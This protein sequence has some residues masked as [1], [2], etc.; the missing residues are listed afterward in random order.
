[1]SPNQQVHLSVKND[2][3]KRTTR[4]IKRINGLQQLSML[5]QHGGGVTA[6]QGL[7][8]SWLS[9]AGSSATHEVFFHFSNLLRGALRSELTK[10]FF[11][12]IVTGLP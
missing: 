12:L 3:N 4:I 6:S 10:L 8:R 2:L 11:G 5:P 7:G 9:R 1:M